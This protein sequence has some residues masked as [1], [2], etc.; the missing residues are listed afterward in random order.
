MSQPAAA[1][2]SERAVPGAAHSIREQLHATT[3]ALVAAEEAHLRHGVAS[4]HWE[5][6]G[7]LGRLVRRTPG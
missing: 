5:R 3:R 2:T 4:V 6:R 1:R 7:L